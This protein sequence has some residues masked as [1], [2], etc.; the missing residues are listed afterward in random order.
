MADQPDIVTK[1]V[2]SVRISREFY[3]RLQKE[4]E[5]RLMK[6]NEF[7]RYIVYEATEN[8][9]LTKDDYKVIDSERKRDLAK[10]IKKGKKVGGK[11]HA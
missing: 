6:F 9:E 7:V 2:L 4:A 1:R 5:K 8:V 11:R 10:A 3:R